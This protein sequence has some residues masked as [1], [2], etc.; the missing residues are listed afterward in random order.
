MYVI[1]GIIEEEQ[2]APPNRSFY[3][4][5]GGHSLR[6]PVASFGSYDAET[7]SFSTYVKSSSWLGG[8]PIFCDT[9]LQSLRLK[10]SDFGLIEFQSFRA[11]N[12]N[13]FASGTAATVG[14]Y[15][16]ILVHMDLSNP[17]PSARMRLW[18]NGVEEG[19][20]AG[21]IFETTSS[22][23][24]GSMMLGNSGAGR[25]FYLYQPILFN[26]VLVDIADVYDGGTPIEV[27]EIAGA[28][29]NIQS[30]NPNITDDWFL[31]TNWTNT[32]SVQLSADIPV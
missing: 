10:I 20:T 2:L 6:M 9:A 13:T 27:R 21:S 14:V 32:T 31:A 23:P 16:H 25:D 26:N 1:G 24:G 15:N 22:P 12:T 17:S 8:V 18:L 19:S 7:L 5:V 29:S 4:P 28:Y 30:D 11:G 3:F